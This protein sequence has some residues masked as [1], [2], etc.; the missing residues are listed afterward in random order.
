MADRIPDNCFENCKDLTSVV[1]HDNVTTIGFAA[2]SGCTNLVYVDFGESVQTIQKSAFDSCVNLSNIV[3]P[4]SVITIGAN[5]FYGCN[6]KEVTLP[7]NLVKIEQNAFNTCDHIY[8]LS[9]NPCE[10]SAYPFGLISTML[11]IHVPQESLELY[12]SAWQGRLY[13]YGTSQIIVA[14]EQN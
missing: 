5:A 14:T 12:Q 13:R 10:I 6:L 3:L 1:L 9:T 8:V 4:N 11:T 7:A 2:F